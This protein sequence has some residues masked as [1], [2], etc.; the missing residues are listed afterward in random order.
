MRAGRKNWQCSLVMRKGCLDM[1]KDKSGKCLGKFA[2]TGHLCK[3]LEA[4]NSMLAY[5]RCHELCWVKFRLLRKQYVDQSAK[6]SPISR[7]AQQHI[8]DAHASCVTSKSSTYQRFRNISCSVI[9]CVYFSF[10][11]FSPKSFISKLNIQLR[12]C[13]ATLYVI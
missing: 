5:L 3:L 8:S 2:P 13:C 12:S 10:Y 6:S 9:H 7:N 4:R 11:W 1:L